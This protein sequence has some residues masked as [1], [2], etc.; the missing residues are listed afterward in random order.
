M[1]LSFKTTFRDLS[2]E[3]RLFAGVWSPYL[4]SFGYCRCDTVDGDGGIDM[5]GFRSGSIEYDGEGNEL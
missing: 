1:L 5:L 4:N 3:R 2:K